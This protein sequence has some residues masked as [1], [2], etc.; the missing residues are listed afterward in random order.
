MIDRLRFRMLECRLSNYT[1]DVCRALYTNAT[2][3]EYWLGCRYAAT[4]A[5]GIDRRE[6]RKPPYYILDAESQYLV[7]V[8]ILQEF[9]EAG[10][11]YIL[12]TSLSETSWVRSTGQFRLYTAGSEFV[13][14]YPNTLGEYPLWIRLCVVPHTTNSASRP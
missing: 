10:F 3:K 12:L 13:S 2:D 8:D 7:S 9:L 11:T 4:S 6:W 1:F 5:F 14:S